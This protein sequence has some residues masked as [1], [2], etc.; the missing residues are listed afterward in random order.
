M[1]EASFAA[2]SSRPG[3]PAIARSKHQSS[4]ASKK[5]ESPL[6]ARNTS[7]KFVRPSQGSAMMM[8][9]LSCR[10]CASKSRFRGSPE[11]SRTTTSRLG[12]AHE[13]ACAMRAQGKRPRRLLAIKIE[14]CTGLPQLEVECAASFL[15][16]WLDATNVLP[17]LEPRT[18]AGHGGRDSG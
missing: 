3:R 5:T 15:S 11:L 18:T 13:Q 2:W 14:S 17:R 1:T 6:A 7:E 9:Q 8:L 10:K 4:S 12:P 16:D